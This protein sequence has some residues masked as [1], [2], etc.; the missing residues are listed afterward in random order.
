MWDYCAYGYDH[1]N[2]SKIFVAPPAS[3]K[4][5]G[6]AKNTAEVETEEQTL[7]CCRMASPCIAQVLFFAVLYS[8]FHL[9]VCYLSPKL[10]H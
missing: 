5:V 3:C 7:S 6:G 2:H 9:Q 1:L 8:L 10:L 4:G